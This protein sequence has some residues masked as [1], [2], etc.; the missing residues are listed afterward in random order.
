MRVLIVSDCSGYMRGGVPV[1]TVHLVRGLAARGHAVAL[2][3][4]VPPPGAEAAR[5][6]PLTLPVGERL[7]Q[8]LTAAL[9]SFAPDVVHV[10][11]M[12]S[13]GISTLAGVLAGHAWAL[14]CHSLPPYER[15]LNALHGNEA[16]HYGARFVRF[17]ANTLAW[18]MLMRW[19]EMP[20]VIVHSEAMRRTVVRYGCAPQRVTPIPF[21]CGPVDR[22]VRIR[23]QPADPLIVT[24][25][26]VAHTKGQ[27]D[28]VAAVAQLREAFPGLRYRILGEVR[29]RSYLRFLE[30]SIERLHL[31]G[32]VEVTPSPSNDEKDAILRAADLYLQPSHEEG[33]CLAYIEAAAVVPRLVGTD[34]GAIAL[35]G[36]DDAAAR[37][38][39]PRSPAQ[40]ADAMRTLLDAS[41][42]D[43]LMAQRAARLSARFSWS[44]YLDA[45]EALYRELIAALPDVPASVGAA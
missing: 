2:A 8:E 24:M 23:P 19:R 29:D 11:A 18:K 16:L 22:G 4:D 35:I 33:F 12:S 25:G 30:R 38:V 7:T 34:T 39:S 36:A 40:L 37:T 28:A 13:R 32:H 44:H 21:G 27:H 5:H 17:A 43:N 10:M 41:L 3:G 26:G 45:H 42:P 1:E 6:W 14:T 31:R 15:K 9:D 20:R